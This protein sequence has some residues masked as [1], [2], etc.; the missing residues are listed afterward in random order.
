MGSAYIRKGDRK[1]NRYCLL[2]TMIGAGV[3]IRE[4]ETVRDKY[5][6]PNGEVEGGGSGKA[7]S[8][9]VLI[10]LHGDVD[11]ARSNGV[12]RAGNFIEW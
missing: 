7:N 11:K 3:Y 12:R 8:K 6:T 2:L 10:D 5:S 9:I 1:W 4:S